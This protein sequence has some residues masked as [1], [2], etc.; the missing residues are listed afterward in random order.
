MAPDSNG[1]KI[2]LVKEKKKDTWKL[3]G[4]PL[5]STYTISVAQ[6]ARVCVV[7]H[8]LFWKLPSLTL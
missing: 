4:I 6:V 8:S 3:P 7:Q 2:L 5:T 1:G